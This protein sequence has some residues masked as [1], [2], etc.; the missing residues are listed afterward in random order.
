MLRQD[1]RHEL[2]CSACGA[3]LHD[4]KMLRQGKPDGAVSHRPRPKVQKPKK[5]KRKPDWHEKPYVKTKKAKKRKGLMSR[6]LDEAWDAVE[7]I[8]D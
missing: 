2:S 7:D 3:P 1:G 5:T 4:L 6:F 8:F